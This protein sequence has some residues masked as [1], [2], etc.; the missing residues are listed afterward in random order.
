MYGL[1]RVV[2]CGEREV[3]SARS[4]VRSDD[5]DL[6]VLWRDDLGKNNDRRSH[7]HAPPSPPPNFPLPQ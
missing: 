2:V 5:D 6:Q 1:G 3:G 4:N 7:Y